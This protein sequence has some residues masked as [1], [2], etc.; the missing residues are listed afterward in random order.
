L[1]LNDYAQTCL[2]GVMTMMI[3]RY[4]TTQVAYG[5]RTDFAADISSYTSLPSIHIT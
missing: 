4:I 2:A 5:L 1:I 3:A